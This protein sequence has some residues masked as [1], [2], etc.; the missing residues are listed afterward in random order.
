[1]GEGARERD[2]ELPEFVQ[3]HLG[4]FAQRG[5]PLLEAGI[6]GGRAGG[7]HT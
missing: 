5:D 4:A 3:R 7:N 2:V 6:E 1:M